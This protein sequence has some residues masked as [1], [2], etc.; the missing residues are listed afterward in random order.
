MCYAK[1]VNFIEVFMDF[2]IPDN[3]VDTILIT[4]K[5][6]LHFKFSR[7]DQI[8]CF[9]TGFL[10]TITS[11]GVSLTSIEI[12]LHCHFNGKICSH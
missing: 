11:T 3:I 9:N 5:K 1:F 12:S 4:D 10:R 8:L 2:G 6:L 7:L